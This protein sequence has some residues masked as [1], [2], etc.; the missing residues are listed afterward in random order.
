MIIM[1]GLV[2]YILLI[3]ILYII[4]LDVNLEIDRR[5]FSVHFKYWLSQFLNV[6]FTNFKIFTHYSDIDDGFASNFNETHTVGDNFATTNHV[7]FKNLNF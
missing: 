1:E 6:E 5:L 3:F 2:S 7:I 4:I